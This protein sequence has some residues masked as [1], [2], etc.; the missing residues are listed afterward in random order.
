V[1]TAADRLLIEDDNLARIGQIFEETKPTSGVKSIVCIISARQR[2]SMKSST[3]T[4]HDG[5]RP[6][7]EVPTG[8]S[9]D[10]NGESE[11]GYDAQASLPHEPTFAPSPRKAQKKGQILAET[12]PICCLE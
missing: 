10:G 2:S 6:D 12:K 11:V 5:G 1:G 9:G 7:T 8:E 4:R 3:M